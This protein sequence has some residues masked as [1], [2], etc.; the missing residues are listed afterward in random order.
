MQS[1][2]QDKTKPQYDLLQSKIQLLEEDQ[3]AMRILYQVAED[4]LNELD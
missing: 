2:D 4:K 3:E 1:I